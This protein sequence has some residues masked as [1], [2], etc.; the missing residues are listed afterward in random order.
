MSRAL[1]A[2]FYKVI[3]NYTNV[4]WE[5]LF[6]F[7]WKEHQS[8]LNND[9][10]YKFNHISK[11]RNYSDMVTSGVTYLPIIYQFFSSKL[12]LLELNGIITPK[13]AR[14]SF[15]HDTRLALYNRQ[16]GKCALSN[17]EIIDYNDTSKYHIDHDIPISKWLTKLNGIDPNKIS[18]LQL[19]EKKENLIKGNEG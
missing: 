6:N 2:F 18:N 7:I 4:Q 12:L 10:Q 1:T 15:N 5:D 9:E 3:N 16:K 14:G 8:N 13:Q 19:V 17:N 11:K